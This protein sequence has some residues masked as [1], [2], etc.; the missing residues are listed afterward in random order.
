MA[1]TLERRSSTWRPIVVPAEAWRGQEAQWDHGALFDLL[2]ATGSCEPVPPS[3]VS[4]IRLVLPGRTVRSAVKVGVT[5]SESLTRDSIENPDLDLLAWTVSCLWGH[6]GVV[7]ALSEGD[8]MARYRVVNG[9]TEVHA[10]IPIPRESAEIEVIAISLEARD[11][12]DAVL[13]VSRLTLLK[14]LWCTVHQD[15]TDAVGLAPIDDLQSADP[16]RLTPRQQAILQ[17]MDKGWTNGQIARSI[18]FSEST[19]R[20]ESM[21]IYRY[22]GVHARLEAVSAARR[23][24]ELAA[25]DDLEGQPT[26]V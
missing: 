21:R 19:V 13:C 1:L 25:F 7:S 18:G 22:F 3:A 16:H 10:C 9:A 20:T 6:A 26:G 4:L 8:P 11:P 5:A 23:T 15:S 24:G 17:A 12:D 2:E 14:H